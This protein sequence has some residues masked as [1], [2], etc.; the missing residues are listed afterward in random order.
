MSRF[1]T[2]T[3]IAIA[4]ASAATLALHG[5]WRVLAV[6]GVWAIY[7]PVFILGIA[8]IRMQFFCRA[9]CR[10][11]P[12]RMRVALTFDDGP[13][14]AATPALLDLLEREHIEATFFCIGKNV[15]AYPQLANRIAEGGHLLAN[16]TYRHPWWIGLMF[17]PGLTREMARTQQAIQQAAG[18][19]PRYMRP[20]MG[21][22][23]PH[24]FRALRK[25]GLTVV[26]WDV[27]SFDTVGT[28]QAAVDRIVRR[29]RDGS[30]ILLHDGGV[31]PTRVVEIVSAAISQLRS[32]GF[33]FE[34]LDRLLGQA[35]S[36]SR[37]SAMAP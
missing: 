31:S 7:L 24:Y 22:T 11:R 12:G 32:R 20:P 2:T 4:V 9:I 19:T 37:E 25:T 6:A 35:G 3:I 30:I 17:S 8:S 34:R 29:T 1:V 23:N 5:R 16:H 10:G 33:E 27:R 18:L 28:P 13:D 21:M 36:I 14:P 15:A 26:G